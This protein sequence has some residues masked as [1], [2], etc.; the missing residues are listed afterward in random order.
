MNSLS[1]LNNYG[2]TS[3]QYQDDRPTVVTFS[4]STPSN[5][6][7]TIPEGS[8]FIIP[9]GI[10]VTY[11]QS[12]PSDFT[13]EII[14]PYFPS[15][16]SAVIPYAGFDIF[17]MTTTEILTSGV[18]TATKYS[19][20]GIYSKQ[21]WDY[22]KLTRIGTGKDVT[23]TYVL[24]QT[25]KYGTVEK[26]WTTTVTLEDWPEIT[27]PTT[28]FYDE[29]SPQII[30]GVPQITD[31][32]TPSSDTY[33]YTLVISGTSG[34]IKT[35]SAT[36]TGTYETPQTITWDNT[37]K[38]LTLHG[39][40]DFVNDALN[41]VRFVPGYNY[42]TTPVTLTYT[43]TNPGSGLVTVVNQEF[44]LRNTHLS[45]QNMSLPRTFT[46]NYPSLVFPTTPP[47]IIENLDVTYTIKF[48]LENPDG[49]LGLGESFATP[50][51]W[52]N[53]TR[54]YTYTGNQAQVNLVFSTLRFFPI[55]DTNTGT[56]VTYEQYVDGNLVS[57]DTFTLTV[58]FTGQSRFTGG[59]SSVVIA[60]DTIV[61]AVGMDLATLTPHHTEAYVL[62]LS[63]SVAAGV[64]SVDNT[65]TTT[66]TQVYKN[67][68][69]P[70]NLTE[71]F[72]NSQSASAFS[73]WLTPDF[74]SVSPFSF[75]ETMQIGGT[76]N[77]T[78]FSGGTQYT[79]TK[80]VSMNRHG[81]MGVTLG[82]YY[83]EDTIQPTFDG[84]HGMST[85]LD[86]RM[87]SITGTFFQT[88]PTPTVGNA[89]TGIRWY[90]AIKPNT[91][92]N[93]VQVTNWGEPLVITESDTTSF[94][95]YN[96]YWEPIRDYTGTIGVNYSQ[97]KVVNG[98]T[99]DQGTMLVN[100]TCNLVNASYAVPVNT[101]IHPTDKFYF[102]GLIVGDA[103]SVA[104]T[105]TLTI[106]T[107]T[108]GKLYLN[109]IYQTG[110]TMTF[111]GSSATI[112]SAL[113]NTANYF[114]A[115]TAGTGALKFSLTRTSPDTKVLATNVAI[116]VTITNVAVGD[117][118]NGGYY[119]ATYNGYYLIS[120]LP[121]STSLAS[122]D[123][124]TPLWYNMD[125]SNN[126]PIQTYS[127]TDGYTN[128]RS[129]ELT[130][131][132]PAVRNVFN[133][134][135]NTT[136]SGYS[137][138]YIP[139]LEEAKLMLLTI[140]NETTRQN[141]GYMIATSSVS[142]SGGM[143]MAYWNLVSHTMSSNSQPWSFFNTDPP[144]PV[145]AATYPTL[146]WSNPTGIYGKFIRR[147]STAT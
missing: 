37:A 33:H 118:W 94:N 22:L 142:Y 42:V 99:Y 104:R 28:T 7:L 73:L 43:L 134:L 47:Q 90:K 16:F 9:M 128:S 4:S 89:A 2:S 19:I 65:W 85:D 135:K 126:R 36:Y 31:V 30:V 137:D 106:T 71:Y 54:T 84:V 115:V 144:D 25:V 5:Q 139:S 56:N 60:E 68:S 147:V 52:D 86:T 20:T 13:Y 114:K 107:T 45:I 79:A 63:T 24:Q 38:T 48:I 122:F 26:S 91:W 146:S 138:W 113:S 14:V 111:T 32:E 75:T 124:Q 80:A 27:V 88:T 133:Y 78:T 105:Y 18:L 140:P 34:F 62:V 58:A 95:Q 46:K 29:D 93:P 96:V 23:G 11:M 145:Y 67:F 109:N 51:G 74:E 127:L 35:L 98:V 87:S 81:E 136:V 1:E 83:Q 53:D 21:L 66:S 57:W 121:I 15:S 61:N 55:K 76:Y 82:L 125:L 143:Q 6:T 108:L 110:N 8:T 12:V 120:R 102:T 72:A 10:D 92:T 123:W 49:Y 3:V 141:L 77:G 131:F 40:K 119:F 112:N 130:N 69:A 39:C 101:T 100:T 116:G 41:H 117:F 129:F 64:L 103:G 44:T 70:A 97:S 17:T 50:V 59:T 132:V